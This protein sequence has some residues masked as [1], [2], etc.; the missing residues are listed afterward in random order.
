MRSGG[1]GWAP[2][3]LVP[4]PLPV[5]TL[6][7][8]LPRYSASAQPEPPGAPLTSPLLP[9]SFHCHIFPYAEHEEGRLAA[10]QQVQQQSHELQEVGAG[11][12]AGRPAP[13]HPCSS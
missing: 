13:P 9:A 3:A 12:R 4:G 10:L 7:P 1:G 2:A 6:S 5:T 11:G 8:A